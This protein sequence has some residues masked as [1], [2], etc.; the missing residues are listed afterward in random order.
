VLHRFRRHHAR[1]KQTHQQF[2]LHGFK[3]ANDAGSSISLNFPGI[4]SK[5]KTARAMIRSSSQGL[6][7]LRRDIPPKGQQTVRYYAL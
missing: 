6:S 2:S 7:G 1:D 3:I 5:W 4:G